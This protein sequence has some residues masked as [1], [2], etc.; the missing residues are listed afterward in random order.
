MT[1]KAAAPGI[2]PLYIIV[3]IVSLPHLSETAYIPALPELTNYFNI[4]GNTAEFSLSIYMIGFAFGVLIW[5][6]VSDIYGRKSCLVVALFIYIIACFICYLTQNINIFLAARFIKALGISAGAVLGQAIARDSNAGKERAK[7]FSTVSTAIAFAPALGPNIGGIVSYYYVWYF[8]FII[9]IVIAVLTQILLAFKLPETKQNKDRIYG[10]DKL[11]KNCFLKMIKDVKLLGYAFMIGG[12]NGVLF[13]YYAEA[14]FYFMRALGVSSYGFGLISFFICLPLAMGGIVS[15]KMHSLDF[16]ENQIIYIGV[17]IMNISAV[18]FTI[19]AYL[20]L[21]T[22]SN[23]ALSIIQ[24]LLWLG[25][26]ITGG[27]MIIPNCLSCALEDYGEFAGTAASLFGFIYYLLISVFTWVMSFM[28]NGEV[29]RLP[30]FVLLTSSLMW[31]MFK[32]TLK[33]YSSHTHSIDKN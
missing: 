21:I 20:N 9:L 17:I 11:Y 10:I 26:I 25:I 18:I 28:H 5:G 8:V 4:T 7:V 29:S 30:L 32:L 23:L 15:K 6:G 31:L 16:S 2:V 22:S 24:T 33:Y 12:I 13:G 27:T 1:D 3:L 14:P 19:T